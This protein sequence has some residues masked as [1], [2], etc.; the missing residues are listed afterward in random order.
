[1]LWIKVRLTERKKHPK[2]LKLQFKYLCFSSVQYGGGYIGP[3]PDILSHILQE[4]SNGDFLGKDWL[5]MLRVHVCAWKG[6]ES[7]GGGVLS[8]YHAHQSPWPTASH[9]HR[10]WQKARGAGEPSG[11]LRLFCHPKRTGKHLAVATWIAFTSA[12]RLSVTGT[13]QVEYAAGSREPLEAQL[14]EETYP[15]GCSRSCR[16]ASAQKIP[17]DPWV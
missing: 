4:I 12:L 10:G 8:R 17:W 6:S 1:M 16:G 3:N 14:L 9:F 2:I 15:L 13:C 5:K 7:I 11:L